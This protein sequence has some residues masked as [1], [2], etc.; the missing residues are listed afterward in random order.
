M[1][2]PFSNLALSVFQASLNIFFIRDRNFVLS[3]PLC[4]VLQRDFLLAFDTVLFLSIRIILKCIFFNSMVTDKSILLKKIILST[5]VLQVSLLSY[6]PPCPPRPITI[7]SSPFFVSS[8]PK[9]LPPEHLHPMQL[10]T[11]HKSPS[12][13]APPSAP[14]HQYPK[15]TTKTSPASATTSSKDFVWPP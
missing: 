11:E 8:T 13:S 14:F 3:H 5:I 2:C 10:P 12:S 9:L 1:N 6:S 15:Y 4:P 7:R